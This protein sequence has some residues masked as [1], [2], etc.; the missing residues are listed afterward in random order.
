MSDERYLLDN[1]R[2]EAGERFAAMA[3]LFDPWTY[4]HLEAAGVR[5]G[6]RVWEVGAGWHTVPAW[7]A[8]RVGPTGHVIATDIDTSWLSTDAGYDVIRHDVTVDPP[9][10]GAFDVIHARLLLVHLPDRERVLA[11]LVRA[12]AA[13]GVLLVEDADPAL[14]PLACLVEDSPEAEL[15]NRVRRG[16]RTLLAES[17]ADLAFGRTLLTGLRDAGLADVQAEVFAP[18]GGPALR[19]LEIATLG[20]VRGRLVA[21]GLATDD[22]LDHLVAHLRSGG[23][24][25]TPAPLVS[26]WGR[27][28]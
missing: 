14:Q 5:P 12:L 7:L 26:A 3:E 23:L 19:T 22:E 27:K 16:F 18:Y 9:P 8:A 21:A 4:R 11:T 25:L 15:A 2:A 24:D 6:A 17:G 28:P 10:G 1:A 20:H 13:G